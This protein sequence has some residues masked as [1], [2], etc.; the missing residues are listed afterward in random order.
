MN[1]RSFLT[2]KSFLIVSL[3]VYIIY[4]VFICFV[5]PSGDDWGD[6]SMPLIDFTWS[7]L[8][9][10]YEPFHWRPLWVL[11]GYLMSFIPQYAPIPNHI[12]I[13]V[14][15]LINS[16]LIY[17]LLSL[18]GVNL[19]LAK[20]VSLFFLFSTASISS[21]ASVDGFVV[22]VTTLDLLALIAYLRYK[23]WKKYFIWITLT[24]FS[25][26]WVESGIVWFVIPPVLL[27]L[28]QIKNNHSL[29][30][31]SIILQMVKDILIGIS[32]V[33]I[34][35]FIRLNLSPDGSIGAES[36][37][38]SLHINPL[39]ILQNFTLLTGIS[40]VPIDT[41]SLFSLPRRF[42]I[43]IITILLSL[44]MMFVLINLT[45]IRMK[46]KYTLLNMLVLLISILICMSPRLIIDRSGEMHAYPSLPLFALFIGFI[47]NDIN[48]K[49]K[50]LLYFAIICF[51]ISTVWVNS[52]KLNEIYISGKNAV[53]YGQYFKNNTLGIPEK[54]LL[55]KIMRTET[56]QTTY[57][58]FRQSPSMSYA[59][60][61]YIIEY[62]YGYNNLNIRD[63]ITTI[64]FPK[65]VSNDLINTTI[66]ESKELYE[67]I[68]IFDNGDT[69]VIQQNLKQ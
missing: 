42:D 67:C 21:I 57:S 37:R 66:L 56:N 11:Y 49:P 68:W 12:I 52:H 13:T 47:F 10:G 34:Y 18:F 51:S 26:L 20:I 27:Y 39:K 58:V 15:H 6:V 5:L 65:D 61:E 48:Y 43:S 25:L 35:F 4:S 46:N 16:F 50:R 2:I 32:F 8:L 41:I 44:P 40:L 60:L 14:S 62:V 33:L 63:R 24:A 45:I 36:G 1:Y 59:G 55:I 3:V 17:K 38:Y 64:A 31:K 29:F 7:D 69:K 19:N 9:P 54:I 22:P 28:R 53:G 30:D 23:S